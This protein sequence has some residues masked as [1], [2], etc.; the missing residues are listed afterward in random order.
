M[1]L[2]DRERVIEKNKVSILF[3]V[4]NLTVKRLLKN[5]KSMY[6]DFIV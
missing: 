2:S 3:F 4:V 6:N 5:A 1:K